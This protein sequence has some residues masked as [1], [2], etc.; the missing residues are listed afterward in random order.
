[1]RYLLFLIVLLIVGCNGAAR[2]WDKGPEA[3]WSLGNPPDEPRLASTNTTIKDG[4]T[5]VEKAGPG[6]NHTEQSK[7]E[8]DAKTSQ[9]IIG[10][11]IAFILMGIAYMIARRY[12]PL[13]PTYGST[14]FFK[15]GASFVAWGGA[16][17]DY[18]GWIVAGIVVA[19]LVWMFVRSHKHNKSKAPVT[20]TS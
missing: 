17:P 13:W 20:N 2:L 5:R 3:A 11:G 16:P 10:S 4:E 6:V 19:G 8:M 15:A 12:F 9:Y 7:A 18:R 14:L 1:M